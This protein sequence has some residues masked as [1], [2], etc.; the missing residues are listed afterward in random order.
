MIR[1]LL[2][3]G[4]GGA[5]RLAD[6]GLLLFRVFV[7]LALA[8]GHGINKLP[9]SEGFTAG[10]VEMGFPAPVAFAWAAGL[11]EFV[12]GH[13]IALGLLTRP[14][15]LF[16]G[17]TMYVAAFIR[18]AGDPFADIEKALLFLAASVLLMLMGAGRCSLDTMIRRHSTGG[19]GR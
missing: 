18:Q 8:W 12:G 5:S 16:A 3:G 2:F 15:A 11:A 13:L 6:G 19:A 17:A 14:A 1:R 10:V 9:P 4:A 7:G